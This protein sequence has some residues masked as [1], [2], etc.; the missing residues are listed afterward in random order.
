MSPGPP[1]AFFSYSRHDAEFVLKL[2]KD[3]RAAGA[4]LWLDQL[5]ITAGQHWD[6]SIAEALGRST[7]LLVVLSPDSVAS[8]N[9]MDEVSYALDEQKTVI[10]VLHKP[11]EVP[12][13]LRRTQ[14][15]DFTAG[16]EKGLAALLRALG[17]EQASPP[18]P[19][20]RTP[21]PPPPREPQAA[22]F[23]Q[24]AR[25][26]VVV[27]PP[28]AAPGPGKRI[29]RGAWI[30]IAIGVLVLVA[31][32]WNS[33]S[34]K[35][36]SDVSNTPAKVSPLDGF[37]LDRFLSA[38]EGPSTEALRPFFDDTVSPYY[39]MASAGW[40]QIAQD[41]Q[42]YFARFPHIAYDLVG[43]PTYQSESATSGKI[44]FITD[45]KETQADGRTLSG[46][47]QMFL[48]V[49]YVDGN[50]KITAITERKVH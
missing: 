46:R 24:P 35:P 27:A 21:S 19:E 37:W 42:A 12:F 4:D 43:D 34:P 39:G 25:E 38:E 6:T 14:Y 44:E 36:R 49:R 16:Y 30:G 13:R 47:T 33:I 31:I 41:K 48:A 7:R 9:V 20:H 2:A 5:D 11:C 10:P 8:N 18:Q 1:L 23:P 45:Y 50:W 40:W 32:L 29:S 22:A 28:I 3:L 26:P 17:V 15:A